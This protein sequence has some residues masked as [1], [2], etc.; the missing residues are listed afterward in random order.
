[1]SI[2]NT[3]PIG[4]TPETAPKWD[5]TLIRYL[6]NNKFG[7]VACWWQ[8]QIALALYEGKDVI[9]VAPTGA[10]KTL[11]FWLPILMALNDGHQDKISFVVTSL[12]LLWKQNVQAL[13]KAGI[14]AIAISSKN[15][16]TGIFD[17]RGWT[18]ARIN[19]TKS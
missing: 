17:V 10:G 2:Y 11:T 14:R 1:M 9:G 15:S 5:I 13:E 6:V 19:L 16:N 4:N 7:K 8:V 18:H 3:T 12:N